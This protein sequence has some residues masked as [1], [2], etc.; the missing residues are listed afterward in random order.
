M[1]ITKFY[2]RRLA[3]I[4]FMLV[5]AL[6]L[7]L[8]SLCQSIPDSQLD[9]HTLAMHRASSFNPRSLVFCIY[10][11]IGSLSSSDPQ[12]ASNAVNVAHMGNRNGVYFH[13]DDW[14]D[15]SPANKYLDHSRTLYPDGKCEGSLK[16]FSSVNPYFMESYNTKM[17]RG[18]VNL[19][20][21]KDIPKRI[22]AATDSGF[23]EIPVLGRKRIGQGGM[24]RKISK[25]SVV[26]MMEESQHVLSSSKQ[27]G[28]LLK[29]HP[30][31]RLE[32]MIDIEPQDFIFDPDQQIFALKDALNKNTILGDDLQ[33]LQF[34]EASNAEVDTADRFFKYP[35]IYTDLIAGRSH[36]TSFPFFKRYISNRER[37]AV[38]HHLVRVWFKFAETQ[39]INSWINYGSL[40]GWAYNGV[41]M[42]WDTDIDIQLPIA[43][44]D[45]LSRKF[46]S[47]IIIENPRD[48]NAKYLFEVSPTY[49]RQGNGRNFIDARFIDINSGLYIDISALSHTMHQAP[50]HLYESHSDMSRLK[51]M[52]VHCKN[53]NW[54]SLEE[55]LPIRHNYFEGA[56]VYIPH[57]VLSILDRKYGSD[58]YTTKL[59][60]NDHT[61]REDLQLWVP[62]NEC[63]RACGAAL[64][65]LGSNKWLSKCRSQWLEDEVNIV[66][67]SAERHKQLNVG[68][69]EPVDYS[70]TSYDDLP[71]FR[72]DPWDYFNDINNRV[73]IDTNWYMAP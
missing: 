53:W 4:F 23:V 52:P 50:A 32:K 25:Q 57:N 15:L 19:Y 14:V 69:D 24:P 9:A 26:K 11:Y 68:P 5:L 55:L 71:L 65:L 73:A 13:W 36:H 1:C 33:Y 22:L 10:S 63:T 62:E 17:L 61:Y 20:C 56:S 64:T 27:M 8:R 54:H 67:Q 37:Q 66:A 72:K 31:K 60:F 34:L 30:Y 18:M 46:N 35:W 6:L 40:L 3:L 48:G 28:A 47:T 58:S 42:P 43:Q 2:Q 29:F 45:R 21:V 39:G 12:R 41:N 44:L 49:I 38:L 7:Y 51:S 70:M 59:S 16:E